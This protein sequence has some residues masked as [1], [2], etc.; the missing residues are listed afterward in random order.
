MAKAF[1]HQGTENPVELRIVEN[2]E[3]KGDGTQGRPDRRGL[4]LVNDA[5][6]LV[7]FNPKPGTDPG[8]YT[9]EGE[10]VEQTQKK[11]QGLNAELK[12]AEE[13]AKPKPAK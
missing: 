1:Y 13:A 9:V 4:A 8:Q 5:G 2:Y 12:A 10:T 11:A 6:E 7:V 3:L